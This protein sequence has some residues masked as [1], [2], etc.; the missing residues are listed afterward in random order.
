[1]DRRKKQPKANRKIGRAN[2]APSSTSSR[3]F[4]TALVACL[5]VC[6]VVVAG[7]VFNQAARRA[8]EV[9]SRADSNP[10][11]EGQAPSLVV[12]IT[13]PFDVNSA[14]VEKEQWPTEILNEKIDNQLKSLAHLLSDVDQATADSF[15][16]IISD[17]VVATSLQPKTEACFN[18]GS[19][20]VHRVSFK[21][22]ETA[23]QTLH[24]IRQL[25]DGLN[26]MVRPLGTST[27]VYAKFKIVHIAIVG[28]IATTNVRVSLS[29]ATSDRQW[30]QNAIWK[31][32]WNTVSDKPLLTRL[33]NSK[34]AF[35]RVVVHS[36]HSMFSD[37]TAATIGQSECFNGQLRQGTNY[38]LSRLESA[39]GIDLLGSHG[40]SIADVNGDGLDDIY[41]CQPGGLPNRLFVPTP[42]G[43]L[44]E[45]AA[46][47]GL[48]ICDATRSALFVDLDNDG[49]QDLTLVVADQVVVFENLG[50]GT[51]SQKSQVSI[52]INPTAVLAADF[53]S[54]RLLDLYVL[55]HDSSDTSTKNGILGTPLPFHDAN[56]GGANVLLRNL[57]EFE[58]VDVTSEVGLDDNNLR[59]SLAGCWEDYDDDS[60]MDLYVANDFGRNNLYRND[61]GRF[62]DVASELGV[63]DLS[64]GMS[65]S[66]GDV[67]NDGQQDLYV[68][69]MF[70]SAGNRIA[71]QRDFHAAESTETRND[72]QRHSR[73]N[74]L[75]LQTDDQRF[76]D[77][78]RSWNVTMGRWAWA[79]KFG[80]INN[81]GLL[82][83]L[84]TNGFVTNEDTN[85]L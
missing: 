5:V 77:V 35:E 16:S 32:D 21:A 69:N 65:V 10:Y 7:L 82:D 37:Q 74:S 49:D 59:F 71:Y 57:G 80:D 55:N 30:Q 23:D 39:H 24:G 54:D 46:E 8:A 6:L 51:F 53:D 2:P 61:E 72:F 41:V 34:D 67:D 73:G 20:Q 22:Q 84:I 9:P 33:E 29:G 62:V 26:S 85:D 50:V 42:N 45:C 18:D 17:D 28:G 52:R 44:D 12:H 47:F 60:D 38:W 75:F 66:W 36:E 78:S 19:V 3:R 48:D 31:C 63:E 68:S 11:D 43:E 25:A 40:L 56:N 13:K 83:I 64:A 14:D 4:R 81:D 1:M 15:K 27:N 79:S 70:S 58:F 76:Q